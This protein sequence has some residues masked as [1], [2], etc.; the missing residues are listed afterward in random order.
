MRWRRALA[1]CD[2]AAVP[3]FIVVAV[4]IM[5]PLAYVVVALADILGAHAAA[6]H[7]V[8][9]A[10]R[11]YVRDVDVVAGQWRAEQAAVI[12]FADRGLDLPVSTVSFTCEPTCLQPGGTIKVAIDWDMPLPWLPES[13]GSIAR[14][15]IQAS[16]EFVVD[17]FR[18]AGA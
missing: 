8:R 15:P 12:A 6:H 2:G 1:R 3:E 9:E 13:L 4:G 18:P 16:E 14:V 10:G 5:I 11:V 17:S 7:A